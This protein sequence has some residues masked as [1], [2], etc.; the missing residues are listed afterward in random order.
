M[1]DPFS[2]PHVLPQTKKPALCPPIP[3]PSSNKATVTKA[4]SSKPIQQKPPLAQQVRSHSQSVLT[5]EPHQYKN[6]EGRSV[7]ISA[8]MLAIVILMSQDH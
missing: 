1:E 7:P 2:P 8:Y 5:S 3:S 4:Y 6:I